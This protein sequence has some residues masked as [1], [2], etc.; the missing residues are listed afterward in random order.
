MAVIHPTS[1]GIPWSAQKVDQFS[2]ICT[3]WLVGCARRRE[4]RSRKAS[5][6]RSSSTLPLVRRSSGEYARQLGG[7][8]KRM[9]DR[10]RGGRVG[11][12]RGSLFLRE[13]ED[14]PRERVRSIVFCSVKRRTRLLHEGASGREENE[15]EEE[16]ERGRDGEAAREKGYERRDNEER[17]RL[18]EFLS[19][20]CESGKTGE[21]ASSV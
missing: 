15:G 10:R 4:S 20:G 11:E 13:K 18:E 5:L 19:R 21:R 9:R 12:A 1:G 14:S 8:A 2:V 16:R 6:H 3:R 17:E 7:S